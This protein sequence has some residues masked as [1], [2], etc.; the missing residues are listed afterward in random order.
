M[1]ASFA[2]VAPRAGVGRRPRHSEFVGLTDDE[3]AALARDPN[4]PRPLDMP[5]FTMLLRGIEHGSDTSAAVMLR[6]LRESESSLHALSREAADR[7]RDSGLLDEAGLADVERL[8][9]TR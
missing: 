3:V 8:A 1:G 2:A 4:V 7:L 9:S 5:E 6:R